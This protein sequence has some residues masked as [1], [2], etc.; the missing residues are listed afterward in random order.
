MNR[1]LDMPL[2][3]T[4]LLHW[5]NYLYDLVGYLH[6]GFNQYK[7]GQNPFEETCPAHGEG[8]TTNLPPGDTHIVYPGPEG[9][10]GSV[11]LEAMGAGIEDYELLR[12]LETKNKELA[13]KTVRSCVRS[14]DDV[15]E[16][17]AKFSVTHRRL[18]EDVS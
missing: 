18:L 9:P 7:P 8:G 13:D 5:G 3:R 1:L 16:D 4:R 17:S 15:D 11:R 10:W 14:F 6:W 12:L 2:I